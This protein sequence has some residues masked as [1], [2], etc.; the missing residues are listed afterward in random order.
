MILVII[1]MKVFQDKRLELSQT[2]ASLVGSIRTEKGCRRCDFFQSMEDENELCLLEE[3]DPRE[4]LLRHLKSGRFRVLRG[5][6]N[7]LREPYEMMFHNVIRPAGMD[8][9]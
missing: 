3:W 6:M 8:K 4:N 9:I 5:A 2:I 7:L 1:R